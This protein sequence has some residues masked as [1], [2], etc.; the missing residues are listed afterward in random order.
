MIKNVGDLYKEIAVNTGLK[1]N[2]VEAVFKEYVDIV[3]NLDTEGQKVVLPKLG[4]FYI[5][6]NEARDGRNPLTG[7]GISIP[8]TLGVAFKLSGALKKEMKVEI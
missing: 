4:N 8:A 5:K 2:D 1:K 7:E 3:K 6:K